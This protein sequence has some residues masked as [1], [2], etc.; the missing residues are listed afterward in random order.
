MIRLAIL[1]GVLGAALAFWL[2]LPSSPSFAD[3]RDQH[4]ASDGALLARDG[5]LL[6]VTRVDLHERRFTWV[7]YAEIAPALFRRIIALEDR[8]FRR[9]HGVDAIAV[10]GAVWHWLRGAPLRGASTLSM[11]VAALAM[12]D[13][14]E[15]TAGRRTLGQKWRQMRA[16]WSL[17]RHWSKRQI[18]E[19]Y[20]NLAS[21]RGELVGIGA[22][23]QLLLG[24]APARL[25]EQ[26]ALL[27]TMLLRAPN[28]SSTAL[29]MR[30]CRLLQI[31]REGS[32]CVRFSRWLTTT[33]R[34]V[35][36]NI[37]HRAHVAP[38]VAHRLLGA[39]RRTVRSTLDAAVQRYAVQALRTQL[40]QLATRHVRDGAVVVLNNAT[41]DVIAYVGNGGAQ[42]SAPHVDG[43]A[44]LR[45]AG[46]TLKPFLYALALEQKL[47]T[48]ASLLEDSPLSLATPSGLYVPENYSREF[49][50]LASLRRSLANSLN[51]PAIRTLQ[52]VGAESWLARLRDLGLHSL[53]QEAAYYGYALALGSAEVSLLDLTN[54]YRGLARGV[55][56]PHAPRMLAS[57][58]MSE[59][60]SASSRA[61]SFVVADILADR[62]SRSEAFG[63]DNPLV[64]P[65]WAA[66]K[67]GT[68]KDMRDNWCIG[69]SATYTVGAWVGNFDGSPMHDVSGVS[70][71]APL[72]AAVM[73]YLHR[74]R[75][76]P[77]PVPPAGLARRSLSFAQNLE[78]PREEWFL[79]GT[80]P[81]ASIPIAAVFAPRIVSPAPDSLLA[82]DPDIPLAAQH[83]HFAMQPLRDDARW[84]LN[85]VELADDT[86]AWWPL[87]PGDFHLQLRAGTGQV[88]DELRFSVRVGGMPS[89]QARK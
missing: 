81:P 62:G 20:V 52:L 50:G 14:R 32:D 33:L 78:A 10:A 29:A 39:H 79:H 36:D 27:L 21:F 24:K 3:V 64:L 11:Q 74:A 34:S 22:A 41:G 26:D 48:A 73:R 42:S 84:I 51:I 57:R 65:F 47:L 63:L 85:G 59:R 45:Q 6:Q 66:A 4:P 75:P 35:A 54:A 46:S 49:L 72:W 16:A 17:E 77:A 60:S 28:A 61:A 80:E 7:P 43:V 12:R 9:H 30:G 70:G 40:A 2:S 31:S 71:A 53:R 38:H 55:A 76:S 83:L 56:R 68:S 44:A 1:L 82:L 87:E 67:T 69:F 5:T 25:T 88:Y 58:R 13:P 8:R 37:R 86:Q 19:A 15:S 23:S 18:L 89:R